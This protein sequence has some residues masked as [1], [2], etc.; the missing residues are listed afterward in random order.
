MGL[1]RNLGWL[2]VIVSV[3]LCLGC[4]PKPDQN[5]GGDE[6]K[7]KAGVIEL[8][9]PAH[10]RVDRPGGDSTDWK[11]FAVEVYET[12]LTLRIWW[13]NPNV[14]ATVTLYDMFGSQL[15]ALT[16]KL[17]ERKESWGNIRIRKGEYFVKVTASSAESVYTLELKTAEMEVQEA[18]PPVNRPF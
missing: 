15:Y 2:T 12:D 16:H 5:S 9:V 10:D 8:G 18:P 14:R 17:G 13:D 6:K 4:P 1:F 3:F 11:R 7:A